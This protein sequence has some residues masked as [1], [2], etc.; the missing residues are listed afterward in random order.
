M[1]DMDLYELG[2]KEAL[3]EV[4]KDINNL[5]AIDSYVEMFKNNVLEIIDKHI[6]EIEG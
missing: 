6:K 2:S 4:K 1:K 3:E 5:F